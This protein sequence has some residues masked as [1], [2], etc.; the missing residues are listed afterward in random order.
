MFKIIA[1]FFC[2]FSYL[3]I[4]NTFGSMSYNYFYSLKNPHVEVQAQVFSNKIIQQQQ[5]FYVDVVYEFKKDNKL[6]HLQLVENG[7]IPVFKNF[8]NANVFAGNYYTGKFL[9]IYVEPQKMSSSVKVGLNDQ[10]ISL[11]FI[12]LPLLFVSI[13]IFYI[14]YVDN[15]K[16]HTLNNMMSCVSYTFL[17]LFLI[18]CF[19][20]M[21]VVFHFHSVINYYFQ[22]FFSIIYLLIALIACFYRK[23]TCSFKSSY[24]YKRRLNTEQQDNM[25]SQPVYGIFYELKIYG[26]LPILSIVSLSFNILFFTWLYNKNIFYISFILI[27]LC[28]IFLLLVYLYYLYKKVDFNRYAIEQTTNE[29]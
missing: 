13:F 17:Y 26:Y 5:L 7:Q 19:I 16:I 14:A 12:Y 29:I 28:N 8:E 4:A 21:I 2:S 6:Y 27:T 22:L 24:R 1:L 18:G 15:W 9:S 10:E 11:I 3:I 20:S 25:Y 23:N